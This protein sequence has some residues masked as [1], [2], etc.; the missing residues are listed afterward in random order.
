MSLHGG[1]ESISWHLHNKTMQKYHCL[2]GAGGY[3]HHEL[4]GEWL[5]GTASTSSTGLPKVKSRGL[6][7]TLGGNT[8]NG[9]KLGPGGPQRAP[10]A[11][12]RGGMMAKGPN[13]VGGTVHPPH[14]VP[15]SLHIGCLGDPLHV[16]RQNAQLVVA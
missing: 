12:A 2:W 4:V 13:Q 15:G 9:H 6:G 3:I 11:R 8:Y 7:S 14:V 16:P 10:E 5:G 1:L